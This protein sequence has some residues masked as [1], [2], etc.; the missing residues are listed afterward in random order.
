MLSGP[1]TRFRKYER[2]VKIPV[3]APAY[4]VPKVRGPPVSQKWN[5]L[6]FGFLMP[7]STADVCVC[8]RG[9]TWRM[10]KASS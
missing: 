3:D 2:R 6:R 10:T 8:D 1:F 4:R 5:Q 9:S 7:P